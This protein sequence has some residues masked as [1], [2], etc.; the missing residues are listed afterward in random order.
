[1]TRTFTEDEVVKML[2][3]ERERAIRI[4]ETFMKKYGEKADDFEAIGE[5]GS[6]KYVAEEQSE[7]ARK[8]SITIDGRILG[9]EPKLSE[10]IKRDYYLGGKIDGNEI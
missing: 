6:L 7:V 3:K 8:I 5:L 2:T 9:L 1:M 4:A 10:Q